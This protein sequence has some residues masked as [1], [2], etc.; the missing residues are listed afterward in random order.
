MSAP[1]EVDR[2]P[3]LDSGQQEISFYRIG[4]VNYT[5]QFTI[6]RF[7]R[8]SIAA[9]TIWLQHFSLLFA[10]NKTLFFE[11]KIFKGSR[12]RSL[13][14]LT[15]DDSNMPSTIKRMWTFQLSH[16]YLPHP[17]ELLSQCPKS[18]PR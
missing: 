6:A 5:P 9:L 2:S 11:F 18:S 7:T 12:N 15:A 8:F 10:Y 14:T 17:M 1:P 4:C 13:G 3:L 16:P